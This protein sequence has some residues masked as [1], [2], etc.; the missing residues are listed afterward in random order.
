MDRT[1]RLYIGSWTT[2]AADDSIAQL[3]RC[4]RHLADTANHDPGID[5]ATFLYAG[6]EAAL[7]RRHQLMQCV[8][9][10][11]RSDWFPSLDKGFVGQ[12]SFLEDAF[13]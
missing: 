7:R 2:Y 12:K 9:D 1:T 4:P 3:C 8:F 11:D 5:D 13:G 10:A 6:A